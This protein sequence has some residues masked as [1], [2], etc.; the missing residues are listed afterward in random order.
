MDSKKAFDIRQS[1]QD[2]RK[3]FVELRGRQNDEFNSIRHELRDHFESLEHSAGENLFPEDLLS[4]EQSN[5]LKDQMAV[6]IAAHVNG[7]FMVELAS[8]EEEE[9]ANQ[10]FEVVALGAD[11]LNTAD[12]K[13]KKKLAETDQ[14]ISKLNSHLEE[15]SIRLVTAVLKSTAYYYYLR[16]VFLPES[17]P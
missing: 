15:T 14:K 4:S 11:D 13:I 10:L 3:T 16:I 12:E 8:Y 9:I 7:L 17:N 5:L 6:A 2:N 1:I